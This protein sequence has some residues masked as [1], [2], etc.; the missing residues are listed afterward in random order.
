MIRFVRT[1]SVSFLVLGAAC[2]GSELTQPSDSS[3]PPETALTLV[4]LRDDP[5][6]FSYYS[7]L[8]RP[9]RL[10][11]RDAE[12]WRAVWNQI[13]LRQQ[14]VPSL[15]SVDFS[16]EMMVV[17]ALGARSSGGYSILLDG[18]SEAANNGIEVVVNSSSPA[19]D[20]I[21]TAA[22]TQPVDI[23]RVSVRAG[24]VTFVERSQ[25]FHCG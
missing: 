7:G 11:I 15:P 17:V 18:A 4:R 12:A 5:Y 9:E 21:V 22:F 6:S 3:Q 25:V 24:A 23:A 16:R 14:P 10:V 20:C 19:S 13:Y 8:D 2:G 1:V